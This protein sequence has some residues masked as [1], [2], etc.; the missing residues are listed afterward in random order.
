M[1]VATFHFGLAQVSLFALLSGNKY[2]HYNARNIQLSYAVLFTR[3][4]IVSDPLN[5]P[6]QVVDKL[7]HGRVCCENYC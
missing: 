4:N 6:M 5:Q 2:G 7:T 3:E 1:T